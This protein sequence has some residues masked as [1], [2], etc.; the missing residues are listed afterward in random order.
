MVV[1]GDGS[2]G[3]GAVDLEEELKEGEAEAAACGVAGEDYMGGGDGGVVG[4]WWRV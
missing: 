3:G 4:V 1:E 2:C